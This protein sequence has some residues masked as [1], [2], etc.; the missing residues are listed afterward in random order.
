VE[1]L[2]MAYDGL[3]YYIW[4]R[5]GF[6]EMQIVVNTCSESWVKL[7]DDQNIFF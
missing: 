6:E 3:V 1:D 4:R 5:P 2:V 7:L